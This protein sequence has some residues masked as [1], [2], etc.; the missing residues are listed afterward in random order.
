L[1]LFGALLLSVKER[2]DAMLGDDGSDGNGT[3][4]QDA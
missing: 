3:V 4:G 1:F 2:V